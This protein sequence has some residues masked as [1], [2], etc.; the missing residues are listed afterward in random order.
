MAM[1]ELLLFSNVQF[2]SHYIYQM[3]FSKRGPILD[4]DWAH[5]IVFFSAQENQDSPCHYFH[6]KSYSLTI[7][8]L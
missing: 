2:E 4:G 3:A 7:R 8:E 1:T 6:E 5:Q